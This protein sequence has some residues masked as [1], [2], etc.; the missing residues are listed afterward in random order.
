M[1]SWLI[2]PDTIHLES[3]SRNVP[4]RREKKAGEKAIASHGTPRYSQ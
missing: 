2:Q 3:R 4:Q 1:A